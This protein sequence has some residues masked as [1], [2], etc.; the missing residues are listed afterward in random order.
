M[1]LPNPIANEKELNLLKWSKKGLRN[2]AQIEAYL[3]R[4]SGKMVALEIMAKKQVSQESEQT[5]LLE[6]DS[7]KPYKWSRDL[8]ID[9]DRGLY[10]F[11]ERETARIISIELLTREPIKAELN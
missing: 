4:Q 9:Y 7:S 6:L 10:E 1:T 2:K 5:D 11:I 3:V 8:G